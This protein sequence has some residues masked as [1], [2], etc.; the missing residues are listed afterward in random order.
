[1]ISETVLE[2]RKKGFGEDEEESKKMK[3]TPI[4]FWKVAQS[5]GGEEEEVSFIFFFSL[6]YLKQS[7][8]NIMK[9]IFIVKY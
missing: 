5:L 2:L 1:M 8:N 3:W 4:Q 6:I 9:C 7:K